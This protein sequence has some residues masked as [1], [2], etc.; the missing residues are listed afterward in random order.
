MSKKLKI[1]HHLQT[2]EKPLTNQ[3]ISDKLDIP[4][5][6]VRVY[7]NRLKGENMVKQEGKNG[8]EK[9]YISTTPPEI[10][11]ETLKRGYTQLNSLFEA[12]MENRDMIKKSKL[13][14]LRKLIGK[15]IDLDLIEQINGGVKD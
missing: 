5:N 10:D 9:L 8:R 1:L 15:N 3:Q 2:K 12:L 11:Y 7:I 14:Q 4:V 13:N 6:E